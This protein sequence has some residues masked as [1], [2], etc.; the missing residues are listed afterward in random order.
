MIEDFFCSFN[1]VQPSGSVH[2]KSIFFTEGRR[3]GSTY[4]NLV[5]LRKYMQAQVPVHY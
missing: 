2:P 5:E 4:L 1:P 3:E